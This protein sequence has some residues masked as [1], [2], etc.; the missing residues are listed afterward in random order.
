MDS[1][2]SLHDLNLTPGRENM[3]GKGVEG[4]RQRERERERESV[5]AVEETLFPGGRRGGT[6]C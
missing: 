1:S 3:D 4:G 2:S 5:G 6:L